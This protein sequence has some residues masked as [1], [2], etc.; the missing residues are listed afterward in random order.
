MSSKYVMHFVY[1][2]IICA[3][4]LRFNRQKMNK[5]T[6]S[7][8]R[9]RKIELKM[10]FFAYWKILFPMG[11]WGFLSAVRSNDLPF[12]LF[13]ERFSNPKAIRIVQSFC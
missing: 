5:H 3:Y 1:V 12:R 11:I 13:V 2:T 6:T 10:A 8:P 4:I 9:D 7:T